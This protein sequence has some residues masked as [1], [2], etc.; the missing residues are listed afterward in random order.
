MMTTL[1]RRR[2]RMKMGVVLGTSHHEPMMRANVEW[3]RYG[4]GTP[5]D[6][7]V[8]AERLQSFWRKGIERMDGNE[9]V[10]TVG[11]RGDGDKPMT[12]G[13]AI[14]LLERMCA[15]NAVS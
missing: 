12:Q 14:E 1:N 15:I 3:E 5:W 2:W 8:N 13:T 11:M 4:G 9:S 6:Y 7:T 10:V